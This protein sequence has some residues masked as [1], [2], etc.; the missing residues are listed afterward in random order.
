MQQDQF[1][2]EL[3]DF[4]GAAVT[5]FHAVA[6]MV[7]KLQ[8]AG[9]TALAEDEP[10]RL[11]EGGRYYVQRNGSSLIAFTL[12]NVAGAAGGMR[13][14]GAHTDSPCLMVKPEP[15]LAQQGYLQLG[16][17]VYGGALLN[18]WFDRD[19]SIAGR[20]SYRS[21]EGR[22]RT[23]LVDFREPVAIIPSLAIHLDREAN[24]NRSVNPQTDLAPPQGPAPIGSEWPQ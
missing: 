20:V 16:V 13:M 18:P 21:V 7:G 1:N 8:S 14:V 5:P 23:A 24:K 9:F 12:G 11:E 17:Q 6:A 10:W 4:I 19:L 2:R 15:D 22:L 3:C